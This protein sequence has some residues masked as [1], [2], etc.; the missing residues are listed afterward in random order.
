[1]LGAFDEWTGRYVGMIGE[2]PTDLH[3]ATALLGGDVIGA[4]EERFLDLVTKAIRASSLP[5]AFKASGVSARQLAEML[6]A[7]AC[8]LKHVCISRQDFVEKF[9]VAVRVVCAHAR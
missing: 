6:N 9:G 3:E 5:A 1:L 7:N 2:S 4:Y 8:G